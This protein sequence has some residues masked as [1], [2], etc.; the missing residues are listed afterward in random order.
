MGIQERT[1]LLE[2]PLGMDDLLAD[3]TAPPALH[4]G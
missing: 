4:L 1:S 2:A 3:D